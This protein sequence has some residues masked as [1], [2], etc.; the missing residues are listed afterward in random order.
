[1]RPDYPSAAAYPTPSRLRVHPGLLLIGAVVA[2]AVIAMAVV[3]IGTSRAGSS[4]ITVSPASYY[5]GAAYR[6][7]MQLPSTILA[8]DKV[9]LLIDDQSLGTVNVSDEFDRQSDGSWLYTYS[10]TQ[11]DWSCEPT[12]ETSVGRHVLKVEDVAG[13]VLAQG[14]YTVKQP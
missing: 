8:T 9:S 5:C 6:L 10:E 12:G 14:S 2:M 7:T 13:K 1:M 11:G 4:G 3:V